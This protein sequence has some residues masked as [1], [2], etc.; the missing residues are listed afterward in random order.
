MAPIPQNIIEFKLGGNEAIRFDENELTTKTVQ[1]FRDDIHKAVLDY[2][3]KVDERQ[4]A[5]QALGKELTEKLERL[6]NETAEEYSARTEPISEEYRK[7][8]EALVPETE[9][10]YYLMDIAYSCLE[11]ISRLCGQ[12]NKLT[13]ASF[14]EA[15][16]NPMKEKLAYLLLNYGLLVEGQLFLPPKLSD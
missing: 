2:Y 16:W 9:A 7:K 11:V 13:R 12:S 1:K 5:L 3:G 10:N 14:E 4:A 8:T 6:E 15:P